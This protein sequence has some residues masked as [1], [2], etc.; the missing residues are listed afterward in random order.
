[1][2]G[3]YCD[4][5]TLGVRNTENRGHQA[6]AG[7]HTL[8]GTLGRWRTRARSRA[9]LARLAEEPRLLADVGLTRE[10]ALREAAK[11]FWRA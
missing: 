8:A 4:T 2:N 6:L 1:M 3:Q 5:S 11:P 9:E 7:L 10:V